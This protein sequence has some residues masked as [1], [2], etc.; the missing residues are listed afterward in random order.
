MKRKVG[1]SLLL[2]AIAALITPLDASGR[3]IAAEKR[4]RT[5]AQAKIDSQLLYAIYRARGEAK[6]KGVP[7]GD[8]RVRFDVKGRALVWIRARVTKALLTKVRR[9]GGELVSASAEEIR[10]ALPLQRLE[11]LAALKEVRAIMPAEEAMTNN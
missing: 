9:L 3:Q 4:A 7:E 8:L 6:E 11:E 5:S 1:L 2:V 10:A